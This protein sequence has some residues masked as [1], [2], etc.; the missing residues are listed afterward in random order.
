MTIG[1]VTG[2]PG[3]PT[4]KWFNR[5]SVSFTSGE[6]LRTG[7]MAGKLPG[8]KKNPAGNRSEPGR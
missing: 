4:F 7:S 5:V 8:I 2:V 3:R 1:E 6:V